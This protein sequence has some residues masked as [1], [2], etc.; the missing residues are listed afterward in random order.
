M[1]G[2]LLD[3]FGILIC[4]LDVSSLILF[5]EQSHPGRCIVAYK[6]H[7]SEL[8]NLTDEE[9]NAYFA[10]VARAAK[11]IHAAFKPNKVNYGAYGDTGCHLH[12]HLVP[13]YKGEFEWGTPFAMN[14]GKTY[15]TE[16]EYAEMIEKIKA[17]L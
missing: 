3:K 14:P 1:R 4:E 5:K 12:F 10:D 8:V 9:R 17:A 6:D 16:A 15:L 2:E 11:A 13:K 7:V